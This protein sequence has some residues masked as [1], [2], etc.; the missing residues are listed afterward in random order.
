LLKRECRMTI[1]HELMR[2]ACPLLTK[3]ARS[4]TGQG[5]LLHGPL[6]SVD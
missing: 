2:W 1:P 5:P 3:R 4:A 6:S